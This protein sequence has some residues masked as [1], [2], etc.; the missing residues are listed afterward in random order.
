V[1]AAGTIT[2]GGDLEVDRL[3]YGAMRITGPGI[4]G[5]P[6][7]PDG[8]VALLRR[9]AELGVDFIDT[10]DAYGPDVSE[11]LIARALAPYD[12]VV[13][14]TKG[15]LTRSGPGAW[16][17]DGRPEH[18]RE[19]ID[20]SLRRLGVERIDLYQ[21][22]RVDPKVPMAES[23][24]AIAQAQAEGKIR[25]V[26]LSNVSI[27]QLAEASGIVDVVSVQ[28]RYS[29]LDRADEALVDVCAG[30]GIAFIPWFPL[31]AGQASGSVGVL[32]SVANDHGATNGQIAL[33]WLLAR[34]PV[35][36]P[37][38]GTSQIGHLEE[39]LAAAE[40]VLSEAELEM[41]DRVAPPAPPAR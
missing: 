13:V 14:A 29:V 12:G 27:E 21:L 36:V 25:H 1:S 33:A 17:P 30:R 5:P 10:A 26:G 16:H 6:G 23:L 9:A 40:I 34:S 8:A 37:I 39:N 35:I 7:D 20:A 24:G 22:H 19:A 31:A 15:G 28:N 2:I 4:W 18:L 38:P 3:G 41:L 32:A 11:E